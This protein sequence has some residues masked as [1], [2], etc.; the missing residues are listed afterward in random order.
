MRTLAIALCLG[1]A[2]SSAVAQETTIELN[3]GGDT[4]SIVQDDNQRN[5]T[6]ALGGNFSD[7]LKVTVA[8]AAVDPSAVYVGP[9]CGGCDPVA[10]V[11][12]YDRSSTYGA[13]T[14]VLA[15]SYA[16]GALWRMT[17]LPLEVPALSDVDGDGFPELV[18]TFNGDV[19][20]Y[21]FDGGFLT[22][23]EAID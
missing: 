10:F 23:L 2:A 5:V 8:N 16:D 7:L 15:W 17:V 4:L 19:V 18:E 9:L 14:G 6:V 21:S 11:P 13:V 1:L 20:P 3:D 22:P 12:A